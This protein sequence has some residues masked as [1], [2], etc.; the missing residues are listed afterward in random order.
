LSDVTGEH[1]YHCA[2]CGL[3]LNACPVYREMLV[4]SHSPRG[5]VQL[6]KHII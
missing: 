1:V 5:K 3:C 6:A 4:E 2:K